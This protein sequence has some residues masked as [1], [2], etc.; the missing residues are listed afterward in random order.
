MLN[1]DSC[2]AADTGSWQLCYSVP[3]IRVDGRPAMKVAA[4]R[5]PRYHSGAMLAS[6]RILWSVQLISSKRH[7]NETR[8]VWSRP[9]RCGHPEVN[10]F[11]SRWPCPWPCARPCLSTMSFW[12]W[13]RPQL[14]MWVHQRWESTAVLKATTAGADCWNYWIKMR[15]IEEL[16][17]N[18][19]GSY[20]SWLLHVELT[21]W[22]QGGVPEVTSQ[23]MTVP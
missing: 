11:G 21:T 8:F 7:T 14:R 3:L 4:R 5:R 12:N 15:W 20:D 23:A 13:V 6:G 10:L 16:W 22:N 18:P 19:F 2:C 9:Q 1:T 17:G